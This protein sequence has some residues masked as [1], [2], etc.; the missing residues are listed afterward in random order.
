MKRRAFITLLGSAAA[1]P[2][3][4]KAQQPGKLPTIGYLGASTPLFDSQRV[5][6]FVQ[7]LRVSMVRG[8]H[9]PLRRDRNRVRSAQ[10][11]CHS[12]DGRRNPRSKA[13]HVSDSNRLSGGR[14]PGRRGLR[15]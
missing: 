1:W 7:R 11:R 4:A 5:A 6:A 15:R 13:G 14:R 10:G 9:R 8:P 3:A 12:C 2:L